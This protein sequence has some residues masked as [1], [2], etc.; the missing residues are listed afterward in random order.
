MLSLNE[1]TGLKQTDSQ[2]IHVLD[3]PIS[4]TLYPTISV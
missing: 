2:K 4:M 3:R 1:R